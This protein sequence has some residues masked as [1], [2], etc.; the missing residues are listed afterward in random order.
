MPRY[1]KYKE[2]KPIYI[3]RWN[4]SVL[5]Y[6]CIKG[7]LKKIDGRKRVINDKGRAIDRYIPEKGEIV[8][9]QLW[10]VNA[11]SYALF[12]KEKNL[13]KYLY[14][15]LRE[16]ELYKEDEFIRREKR[17]ITVTN[18]LKDVKDVTSKVSNSYNK[19]D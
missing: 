2:N 11:N 9:G 10:T 4:P 15:K 1:M 19:C 18:E 5:T 8:L 7:K 17:Y 6:D 14:Y 12:E 3:L 16:L 13:W